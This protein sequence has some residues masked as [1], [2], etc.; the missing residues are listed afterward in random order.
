MFQSTCDREFLRD[1]ILVDNT[2][3]H[4][5]MYCSDH[6]DE[7]VWESKAFQDDPHGS[8]WDAI[9]LFQAVEDEEEGVLLSS[10]FL[11]QLPGAEN[12]FNCSS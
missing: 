12:H 6:Y 4:A 3:R 2:G 1:V 10:D 11:L 8:P 9:G 7:R 5:V